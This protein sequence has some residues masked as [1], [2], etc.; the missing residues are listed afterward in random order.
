MLIKKYPNSKLVIKDKDIEISLTANNLAVDD[1]IMVNSALHGDT[2]L[3]LSIN[4][5]LGAKGD[6]IRISIPKGY[7]LLANP[8]GIQTSMQVE[9][10]VK[11]LMSLK[12]EATMTLKYDAAKASLFA[13]GIYIAYYDSYTR[14]LQ[15]I[16]TQRITG[17]LKAQISKSGEY[18]IIG[19]LLK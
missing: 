8:F 19:K 15:I 1:A 6:D 17:A 18:M 11:N 10:D 16:E 3:K 7:K 13:G 2:E 12:G 4:R 14:K 9:K 5:N